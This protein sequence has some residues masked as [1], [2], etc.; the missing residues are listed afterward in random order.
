MS[1][2]IFFINIIII[3]NEV[4]IACVIRR[5]YINNIKRTW[6]CITQNSQRMIIISF[7]YYMIRIM[8]GFCIIDNCSIFYFR[9]GRQLLLKLR[10]NIFGLILPYQTIFLMATKQTYQR[11]LLFVCQP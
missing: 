11:C 2:C 1:K 8:L 4:F 9:Q 10:F 7:D 6:M 3:I 5:I